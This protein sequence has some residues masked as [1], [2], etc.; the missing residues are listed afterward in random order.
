[1]CTYI[2]SH[3]TIELLLLLLRRHPPGLYSPSLGYASILSVS[4]TGDLLLMG[5]DNTNDAA[6]EGSR[7]QPKISFEAV[8]LVLCLR[9]LLQM[10]AGNLADIQSTCSRGGQDDRATAQ[11][12]TPLSP[13]ALA[14]LPPSRH[15]CCCSGPKYL[16]LELTSFQSKLKLSY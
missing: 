5:K 12:L 15:C 11:S 1:M 8:A 6:L 14:C 3:D 9:P 13:K 16:V 7:L 2:L 10:Y 4:F